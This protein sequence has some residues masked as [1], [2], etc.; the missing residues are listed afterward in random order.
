MANR[1]SPRGDLVLSVRDGAAAAARAVTRFQLRAFARE[2][3]ASRAGEV[4]PIHQLRVATRRLRA[5]LRLFAPVVPTMFVDWAR[6]ELAWLGRAIGAARDLDVLSQALSKRATRLDPALRGALGPVGLAIHDQ[7]A[8]A[9]DALVHAL[10]SARCRRLLDRLA[11][12][13]ESEAP[14]RDVRRLG[15]LAP[16]LLAPLVRSVRRSGRGLD[17]KLTPELLHR[18]RVRVKR[19]RYALETLRGLSDAHTQKLARRLERMQEL[20]GE[21]QDAVTEIAWLRAYVESGDVSP[22]T[23]LAVGA[24]VHDLSRRARKLRRRFPE[25]WRRLER[26]HLARIAKHGPKVGDRRRKLAAVAR[27]DSA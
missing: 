17:E 4:E 10:D 16:E 6:R 21:H 25:A 20:L 27:A 24:L 2:E 14:V 1:R 18:L 8:A 26:G 12:F 22:A 5:A 15:A 13:A 7:R 23:V 19:L 9:H 11:H 3:R